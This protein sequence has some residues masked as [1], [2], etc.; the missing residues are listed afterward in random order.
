MLPTNFKLIKMNEGEG[1]ARSAKS[2]SQSLEEPGSRSAED[3]VNSK[4]EAPQF[5]DLSGPQTQTTQQTTKEDD[6]EANELLRKF[7]A[8]NLTRALAIGAGGVVGL[9][10]ALL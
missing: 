8:M 5:T 1:G 9:C 2:A 7:A 3:S 6:E 10:T 4:G